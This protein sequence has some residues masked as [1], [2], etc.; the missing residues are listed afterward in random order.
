MF[1]PK[2]V[3]CIYFLWDYLKDN[4]YVNK[5]KTVNQLEISIC[6]PI[7]EIRPEM[8]IQVMGYFRKRLQNCMENKVHHL[9]DVILVFKTD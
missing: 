5:Q 7:A 9:N 3:S 6:Q 4:I 1:A 8:I 2:L